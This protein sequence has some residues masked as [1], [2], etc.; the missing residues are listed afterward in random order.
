[1]SLLKLK[2]KSAEQLK[3]DLNKISEFY[4][5]QSEFDKYSSNSE[6]ISTYSLLLA[7]GKF[8]FI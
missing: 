6:D 1:M 2:K 4:L 8:S 7:Q 3:V 5:R